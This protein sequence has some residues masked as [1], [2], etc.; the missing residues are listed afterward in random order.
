MFA[1]L[2]TQ[3]FGPQTQWSDSIE[4]GFWFLRQL[5]PSVQIFA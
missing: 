3:D 1:R 4:F 2:E 5:L